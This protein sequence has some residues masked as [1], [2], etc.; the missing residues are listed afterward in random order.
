MVLEA[1]QHDLPDTMASC[2]S[3]TKCGCQCKSRS[4]AFKGERGVGEAEYN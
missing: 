2:H 1:F 4:R 3:Q